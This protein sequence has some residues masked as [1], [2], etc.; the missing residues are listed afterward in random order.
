MHR[1]FNL[2]FV[3]V[4]HSYDRAEFS[5]FTSLFLRTAFFTYVALHTCICVCD[6][7][8]QI[9]TL[10]YYNNFIMNVPQQWPIWTKG[11]GINFVFL[12][13]FY[14]QFNNGQ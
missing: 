9:C 7:I 8:L 3:I 1:I 14:F 2:Y 6:C 12:S 10:Q 11:D 5:L 13:Y 4:Q